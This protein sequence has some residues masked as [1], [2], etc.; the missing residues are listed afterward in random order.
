VA[1]FTLLFFKDTVKPSRYSFISIL[2]SIL[3]WGY[4]YP[5]PAD[6]TPL[7][8]AS[9]FK[10]VNSMLA[11]AQKS[12][13]VIMYRA[14]YYEKY[15]DSPSN[16]LI[17][18]L[19]AAK[20]RGVDVS[21]IL[22]KPYKNEKTDNKTNEKIASIL[23]SGG[24]KVYFDSEEITTHSKLIIIDNRYVIIGS[25]NWSY[26]ALSKNNETNVLIDSEQLAKE[27]IKYFEE[28]ASLCK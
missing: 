12:I 2:I 16:K 28:L 6:V 15:P 19:I 24:V 1:E 7:N 3:I 18:S 22:D 14:T 21:V 20:K 9:Y 25:T 5:F 10:T 8:D 23:S 27:Y 17:I 13:Y 11:K 4:A 26:H